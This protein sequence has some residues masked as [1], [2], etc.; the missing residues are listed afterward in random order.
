MDVTFKKDRKDLQ[1]E[2]KIKSMEMEHID[3]DFQPEIEECS[4][5][6]KF[7]TISPECVRCNLC[8]EECP[9][10]AIAGAD[11]KSVV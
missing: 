3:E 6:Q 11:R 9:V 5:K 8:A 10:D 4:L 1:G 7:I 2:V